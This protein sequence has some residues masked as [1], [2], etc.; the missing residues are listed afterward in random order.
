MPTPVNKLDGFAIAGA[1][2]TWHWAAAVIK[3]NKVIVSSPKVET[4]V[5]VRYAFSM[6]PVRA[7]LYNREG[8]PASPFRTDTR[9][10]VRY[11]DHTLTKK[12]KR[13]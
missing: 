5:A 4:P 11:T 12:V 10:L 13:R 3:D 9:E 6:N 7:N 8:L 2:Q 1:D